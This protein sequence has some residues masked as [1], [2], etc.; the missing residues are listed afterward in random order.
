MVRKFFRI[1]LKSLVFLLGLIFLFF[2]FINLPFSKK[3]LSRQVNGLFTKLELPL[4]IQSIQAVRLRTV[5]VDGFSIIDPRGDT[6]I[7]AGKVKAGYHLPA[8][9]RSQVRLKNA[10]ISEVEV[11][12]LMNEESRKL[13]I[14]EAFQKDQKKKPADPPKKKNFW[15]ISGRTIDLSS[16]LFRMTDSLNGVHILQE[17]EELNLK[18]FVLSLEEKEITAHSLE[19]SGL[20]GNIHLAPVHPASQVEQSK[21]ANKKANRTPWNFGA[22]QLDLK[23]IDFNFHQ[24]RDS[25]MLE[26]ELEKARL[27][28]RELDLPGKLIHLDQL[29]L[30]GLR[31]EVYTAGASPDKQ[32]TKAG[33]NKSFLWD[34]ASRRFD[35]EDLDFS[36][37]DY[38][39]RF[40]DSATNLGMDLKEM[41]LRDFRLSESRSTVDLRKLSFH[42]SNGLSLEGMQAELDSDSTS[43]RLE[44][45]METANSQIRLDGSARTGFMDLLHNP[46]EIPAADLRIFD[47]RI[48]LKDLAFL[49]STLNKAPVYPLL[50][51]SPTNIE[52]R[53]DV[54]KDKLE[55]AELILSQSGNFRLGLNGHTENTFTPKQAYGGLNLEITRLHMPWL[56]DVLATTGFESS[57]PDSTELSLLAEISDTLMAPQ[58]D[59]Q[60]NSNRGR[61]RLA[62]YLD[63]LS[64]TYDLN[65]GF[66]HV[67]LGEFLSLSELGYFSGEAG[68]KGKGYSL[69]SMESDL[70]FR[71][72]TLQFQDYAYR[73]TEIQGKISP[74]KYTLNL[75]AKDPNIH[76]ELEAELARTDSSF[77]GEAE[78]TL[79]ARLDLLNFMEDTLSV[80]SNLRAEFERGRDFLESEFHLEEMVLNTPRDRAELAEFEAYFQT[81]SFSTTL[82]ARSDFVNLEMRLGKN[83][84][85]MG[86][87]GTDYQSYLQTFINPEPADNFNRVMVLPEINAT[88]HINYHEVF[89]LFVVDPEFYFSSIS[90]VL[91]HGRSDNSISY[92]LD[93]RDFE[94]S[95]L[96]S[97]HI[98]LDI[99]DSSGFLTLDL[100]AD[101]TSFFSGPRNTLTLDSD[102]KQRNSLNKLRIYDSINTLSYELELASEVD[103]N[104][105]LVKAPSRQML[106]NYQ[107]WVLDTSLLLSLDM[108]SR[109]ISPQLRM[110]TAD[111]AM[112]HLSGR[113][114]YG[115]PAFQ[116]DLEQLDITSFLPDG[117]VP[118]R[119]TGLLSGSLEYKHKDSTFRN[120]DSDLI[121]KKI[122]FAN[123]DFEEFLVQGN[124]AWSDSG[125][126]ALNLG[127]SL[128]S[129]QVKLQGKETRLEPRNIQ[130]SF[131]RLPLNAVEPFTKKYIS[132]LEGTI[133][134]NLG[135]STQG[136]KEHYSG[137]LSFDEARV[138]VNT[139]NAAY[140]ITDQQIQFENERLVFN[141]FRILDT[142]NKALI[143]DGYLD[144]SDPSDMYTQILVSSSNLQVMN[145]EASR[146][147]SFYV[148]I[149][150]DSRIDIKGPL[151]NPTIDGRLLLT[152]GTELFYQKQEDL[153]LSESS[154]LINFVDHAESS[155]EVE[156]SP[157]TRRGTF[158]NSSIKT[159]VEI[160]P[161]TEINFKVAQRIYGVELNIV[162]GGMLNYS[163]LN[164]NQ[165]S[166]SGNYNIGQ[167]EAELKL[168]GWPDKT[169]EILDGGFVRW[170]GDLEDPELNF[171]AINKVASTYQ[172]PLDGKQRNVDFNVILQ[173]SDHLSD[174][175]I[176]L[177]FDTPDQY[178]MSIINTLSPEDQMRQ[179]I[180]ILLFETVDLPGISTTSDYMA[181]QVNQ[182][183]AAQLNQLTRTAIKGVDISFGLDT[184]TQS[185][186]AG[187]QETTTSLS[188]EVSKSLM[189]NRAQ[190][191][192]SGRFRDGNEPPG[193]ADMAYNNITFEYRLDSA[194]TK[195]L[196]VYNE[197]SYED[198]FEGEVIRTGVGITY[199]KRYERIKDIFRRK[200]K[201][202][203]SNKEV[204]E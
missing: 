99:S 136:E 198:V 165:I 52:L 65:S 181:Q 109:Q 17:V 5:K 28:S 173:I 153:S 15:H 87:L 27:K 2:V 75:Q 64:G 103:S 38:N 121:L 169:F 59:I 106:L 79:F 118:G 127:A 200:D 129:S 130:A 105:M 83:M 146:D 85:E 168:V 61:V 141:Q 69:E 122:N 80:E 72:D 57:L 90:M 19:L 185:G 190:I 164:R 171:T 74:G 151:R 30:Q 63:L 97:D 160:D 120:I 13:T 113:T 21:K 107:D 155:T 91:D 44:L 184:Y 144:L 152:Q 112:I 115:F 78:G 189:N 53:A 46:G 49:D 176:L 197:H 119:P 34:I 201:R 192:V 23:H 1:G 81:D 54:E 39:T 163:M 35:L 88:G 40:A 158:S 25:L 147:A 76:G 150:V 29:S 159:I 134:G 9:T 135:I 161:S 71:I 183:L 195:Y 18:K 12:L 203:K 179:A 86:T 94:T 77:R 24:S 43:T 100:L 123:L 58:L 139:L 148:K 42:L 7:Y 194:A 20:D 125:E 166:L 93:G 45:A 108:E 111:S 204:N 199:R 102:F 175:E 149:F 143:V 55:I 131:T 133:S 98:K 68:I 67:H 41:R 174:M 137:A 186:S 31:T 178:L 6:I 82:N 157:I 11:S 60:V 188:Y 50:T 66:E 95:V 191:E 8:L 16:V 4:H 117:L 62:G 167:G 142:L 182:I 140:R 56:K 104:L 36:V 26:V 154:R 70:T 162:G 114:E 10:R 126:Y 96:K 14:A 187:G 32:T 22:A 177:T 196:K 51:A 138:R 128:D 47:S 37:A 124:F 73:K 48:A 92:Q 101:S 170:D 145:R 156:A 172:N 84:D 202:K 33:R 180:T 116:L 89:A 110:F 132:D 3:F 193:A